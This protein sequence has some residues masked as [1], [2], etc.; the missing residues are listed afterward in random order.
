MFEDAYLQIYPEMLHKRLENHG[1][2]RTYRPI[3]I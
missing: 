2:H 3:P 1:F